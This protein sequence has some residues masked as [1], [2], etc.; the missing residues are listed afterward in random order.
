VKALKMNTGTEA[1][2]FVVPAGEYPL[3]KDGNIYY[4][5]FNF[6]KN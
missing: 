4:W 5:T 3:Y 2:G 1:K 6:P